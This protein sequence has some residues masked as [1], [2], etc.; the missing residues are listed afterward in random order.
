LLEFD[1]LKGDTIS[2]VTWLKTIPVAGG[3]HE[4]AALNGVKAYP[5]PS[6]GKL[7][8]SMPVDMGTATAEI[9]TWKGEKIV[10]AALIGK[11]GALDLSALPNGI[12]FMRINTKQGTAT[13][14]I[15]MN[16]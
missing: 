6:N 2:G 4:N 3:V 14:K 5:N 16:R 15:V 11:D 10:T 13:R 9:Y 7:N 12:Y 8:I 1:S